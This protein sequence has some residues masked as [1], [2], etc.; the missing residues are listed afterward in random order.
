MTD[1]SDKMVNL[2]LFHRVPLE[3]VQAVLPLLR[4]QRVPAGKRLWSVG[5][6][7]NRLGILLSGS[8]RA[9]V[10]GQ[11]IGIIRRG[12]VFGEVGGFFSEGRRTADLVS[13]EDLWPWPSW[14]RAGCIAQCVRSVLASLDSGAPW[15]QEGPVVPVRLCFLCFAINPRCLRW[16][17]RW[18][19][20]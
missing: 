10:Q 16:Q 3:Q 13:D 4:R 14:L 5:D 1:C 2:P 17:N 19:C 7:G 20:R 15:S 18:C 11:P 12:G 8:L 6:V 9:R